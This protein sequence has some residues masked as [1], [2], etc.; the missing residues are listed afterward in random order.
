M[1][2]YAQ[3]IYYLKSI[4]LNSLSSPIIGF[5][6]SYGGF[7]SVWFSIK[8]PQWID[9]CIAAS[10]AILD[11]ENEI[12]NINPKFYAETMTYATSTAGGGN[13]LCVN[14]I[15]NS[16]NKIFNLT[17]TENG[18]QQLS[19]IFNLCSNL[20]NKTIAEAIA[21]WQAD[22]ISFMSM[23]SYPYASSY[24]TNGNGILPPY[25]LRYACNT[26]MNKHF[27]LNGNDILFALRDFSGVF[28]NITNKKCYNIEIDLNP[29]M[30]GY[31][32]PNAWNYMSCSNVFMR[33]TFNDLY[34]SDGINDMFWNN[35]WNITKLSDSCFHT[36]GI[37]PRI[38]YTAITYGGTANLFK[39]NGVKNIVFSNGE[40]DPWNNGG[41]KFNNT[42]NGI[43]SISTGLVGHHIDLMFST[44]KDPLTV[45][46]AR[47]FELQQMRNWVKQKYNK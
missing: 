9:G 23:G 45:V 46:D 36:F 20:N 38:N 24:M 5:G 2:D 3:L 4:K 26:Y 17:K 8:Y 35:P 10:A 29:F 16:W 39:T 12:P 32:Y 33:G 27:N 7:L 25:P 34:S 11:F 31:V 37:R 13:D 41:I 18:R 14:N 19:E 28:Y 6:G 42:K 21:F 47:N 40:L 1:A 43:Y 15:R 22:S 44:T 30:P